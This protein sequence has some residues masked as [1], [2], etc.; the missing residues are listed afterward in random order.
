MHKKIFLLVFMALFVTVVPG[1]FAENSA[2]TDDAFPTVGTSGTSIPSIDVVK[3]TPVA[4][5]GFVPPSATGV[6]N[7]SLPGSSG[8]VMGMQNEFLELRKEY[9][10]EVDALKN[11][12]LEGRGT[13]EQNAAEIREE[14]RN[15][16]KGNVIRVREETRSKTKEIMSAAQEQAKQIREKALETQ[17]EDAEAFIKARE[18]AFEEAK[19]IQED[20]KT[21]VEA[22]RIEAFSAIQGQREEF[23][24][25]IEASREEFTKQMEEKKAV[26]ETKIEERRTQLEAELQKVKDEKKK[27]ILTRVSE[28]INELNKRMLETFSK[29]LEKLERVLTNIVTRADKAEAGG[30]DVTVVRATVDAA[31][32]AISAARATIQSQISKMYAFTIQSE[33]TAKSDV[34]AARDALKNDIG[35]VKTA[36]EA[37]RTAVHNAATTLAQIPDVDGYEFA[38]SSVPVS[39]NT[40]SEQNQ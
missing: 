1:V 20:A 17:K 5:P 6:R 11:E 37:A 13:I 10:G 25:K 35:V 2:V 15:E 39:Q 18:W 14:L 31:K 22:L 4:R 40:Q 29:T 19:Q 12:Y 23:I 27:E 21:K 36:V 24:K 32:S 28:N 26:L 38:T 9:R 7:V 8:G 33:E 3:P 16:E 30:R 34:G